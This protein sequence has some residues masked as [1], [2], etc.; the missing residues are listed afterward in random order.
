S[1]GLIRIGLCKIPALFPGY[2]QFISYPVNGVGLLEAT[3][4]LFLHRTAGVIGNLI[5]SSSIMTLL[6]CSLKMKNEVGCF[7]RR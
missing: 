6:M 3:E 5:K 7:A 4:H 1:H 2:A